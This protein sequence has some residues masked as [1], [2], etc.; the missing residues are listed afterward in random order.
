M[1]DFAFYKCFVVY[2]KYIINKDLTFSYLLKIKL[3]KKMLIVK[4]MKK[5]N[6]TKVFII[7]ITGLGFFQASG[8]KNRRKQQKIKPDQN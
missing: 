5:K 6:M 7:L 3:K 8:K 2:I 1:I 4:M